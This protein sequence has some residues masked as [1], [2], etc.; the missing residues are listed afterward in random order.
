MTTAVPNI[1]GAAVEEARAPLA[2]TIA[3]ASQWPL[4]PGQR[5]AL[6]PEPA[7]PLQDLPFPDGVT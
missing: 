3:L 1:V 7:A 6:L 4:L 5:P 2:L